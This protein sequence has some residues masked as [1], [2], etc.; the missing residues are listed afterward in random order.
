MGI[1]FGVLIKKVFFLVLMMCVCF[2]LVLSA[3]V[4]EYLV[5]AV[6]FEK[7]TRFIEWPDG[8]VVNQ[9]SGVFVIGVYGT[10]PFGNTLEKVYKNQKIKNK[11]V[12]IRYLNKMT[13]IGECNMVFICESE[14]ESLQ[15]IIE[16]YKTKPVLLVSDMQGAAESGVHVN[17]YITQSKILFEINESAARQSGLYMSF[18]LLNVA[19]VINPVKG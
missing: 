19:K 16:M 17:F 5:K 14:K 10:N 3:Q 8:S 9:S 7:F 6:W 15:Q 4:D 13:Q 18:R 12:E 2:P 1:L 11:E